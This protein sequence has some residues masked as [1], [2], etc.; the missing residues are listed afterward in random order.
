M[1][2]VPIVPKKLYRG[3]KNSEKYKNTVNA[4]AY[5]E[6]RH[7]GTDFGTEIKNYYKDRRYTRKFTSNGGD[8]RHR[9]I[10]TDLQNVWWSDVIYTSL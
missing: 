2:F 10:R 8:S 9:K 3:M 1:G 6:K 4:H 5:R 7:I